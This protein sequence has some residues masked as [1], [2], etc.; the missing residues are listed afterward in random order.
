MNSFIKKISIQD[1]V[2]GKLKE[3]YDLEGLGIDG[4]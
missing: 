4:G 2:G 1:F 3:G